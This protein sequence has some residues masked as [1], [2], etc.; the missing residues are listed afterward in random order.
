MMVRSCPRPH[1]HR[2]DP[3]A[4]HAST[5]A[6]RAAAQKARRRAQRAASLSGSIRQF[7]TPEVWKQARHA[8]RDAGCRH[9]LRWTLQPL[10]LIG[11]LMTWCAAETDAARFLTAR[12]FYVRA[13]NPKRKRPGKHFSGFY[14]ATQRLPLTVWWA[15]E[16]A[17][18]GQIFRLLADRLI[19][20]G[21]TAFGCDGTRLECPRTQQLE[22]DLGQSGKR[23]SA[24]MLWITALVSLRTGVLWAWRLGTAKASERQ[25]LLDL[26]E[27]LPQ[28]A[29]ATVLLVCDAG[30]VSYELLRTLLD[31][32]CSFLIRLS[33]KAQLYSTEGIEV[34]RFVE[35]QFWYWTDTA[36]K[37]D[38][39]PLRVRVIRVASPKR[40]HDVWLVTN[41]LDAS[42]LTAASAARL[43]RMRWESECFFK[44]YKRVI[45]DVC[46]VSRTT[47]MVAREAEG[48]LLACQLLLAQGAWALKV[49]GARA[50]RDADKCSAARVL[51]EI[52]TEFAACAEPLPT[53]SFARRLHECGRDRGV[54]TGAKV[55]KEHPRRKKHQM[56]APPRLKVLD[57]ERRRRIEELCR[58]DAAA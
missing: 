21:W 14:Q 47:A 2:D 50:G 15:V 36:E 5:P 20:D 31:Q 8:A 40:K 51:R 11:A 42:R 48:S 37:A 7:L 43:Y 41:V 39:P 45:K 32:E 55:R 26:L 24:P 57:E 6:A 12:T 4:A 35:G 29:L 33:S 23:D 30:Y 54:R 53:K 46:L 49:G 52:R 25:H 22:D 18:R 9:D 10:I 34:S 56:P 13:S 3:M 16:A 58:K 17:V 19:V 1:H 28:A 44:I 38:K 27:D